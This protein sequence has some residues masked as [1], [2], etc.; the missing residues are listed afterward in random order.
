MWKF[1]N[2]EMWKFGNLPQNF[3]ISTF[4]HFHIST[5]PHFQIGGDLVRI[6]IPLD[7]KVESVYSAISPSIRVE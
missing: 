1:G 2:L 7:A 5:F 3:H 4:P 6:T